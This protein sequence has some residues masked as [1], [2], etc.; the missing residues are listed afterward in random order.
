MFKKYLHY[1]NSY[2]M[3]IVVV[4]KTKENVLN[5]INLLLYNNKEKL[6]LIIVCNNFDSIILSLY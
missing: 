6:F 5:W 1:V 3:F 2:L 4:A